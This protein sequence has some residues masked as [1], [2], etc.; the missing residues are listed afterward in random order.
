VDPAVA[1]P[2]WAKV[3]GVALIGLVSPPVALIVAGV[4]AR[5]ALL[6][7]LVVAA[8]VPVYR[9]RPE[10]PRF[11]AYAFLG[12]MAML[13]GITVGQFVVA[14][15][16]AATAPRRNW[17]LWMGVAARSVGV[18]VLLLLGVV[19]L[20]I[21]RTH[22][23]EPFRIPS[24]SMLPTLLPGDMILVDRRAGIPVRRGEVIVY[25]MKRHDA[26]GPET[27]LKRGVAIE[28]DVVETRRHE[29]LI[30]GTAL[31]HV[32][33]PCAPDI[34]KHPGD[35]CVT[36]QPAGSGSPY[37]LLWSEFQYPGD[38]GPRT[39]ERG[40]IFVLGDSRDNSLDSRQFGPIQESSVAG[41]ALVVWF[42]WWDGRPRWSRIGHAL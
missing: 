30:N 31:Q 4:R 24:R 5:W 34:P 26:D 19:V 17:R 28:G 13:I 12:L 15:R 2:R 6:Q 36:E 8:A 41:R 29:V 38:W 1:P 9:F 21:L 42:S 27:W 32:E 11:L 39:L 37:A 16:R 33:C 23:L 18:Y 10:R 3:A 40:E 14:V 35:E 22:V 25:R 7:L 20:L